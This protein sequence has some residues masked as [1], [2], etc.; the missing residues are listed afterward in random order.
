MPG[1]QGYEENAKALADQ[2][3]IITLAE[4]HRDA[5]HL[6]PPASRARLSRRC[7]ATH[8]TRGLVRLGNPLGFRFAPHIPKI[9]NS[10]LYLF[11]R[12]V[13][14]QLIAPSSSAGSTSA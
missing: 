7:S 3:E 13:P 6:F 1:T 10:R 11:A 8:A 14:S 5:L 4:T 2:Y 9:G 12:Q